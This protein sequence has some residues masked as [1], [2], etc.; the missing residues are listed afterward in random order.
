M[1][2][3]NDFDQDGDGFEVIS[4][5]QGNQN[6]IH[7]GSDCDDTQSDLNE[8]GLYLFSSHTFSTC[9]LTGRDGPE[10]NDCENIYETQNNWHQD[11]DLFK[12]RESTEL[13]GSH[14]WNI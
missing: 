14:N 5:T 3:A 10:K 2:N 9:G 1:D 6:I 11:E 12:I 4:Y 8:C 7:G 13:E